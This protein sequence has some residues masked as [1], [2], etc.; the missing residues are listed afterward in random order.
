MENGSAK[1]MTKVFS[2]L[3]YAFKNI[4]KG[5]STLPSNSSELT[6]LQSETTQTNPMYFSSHKVNTEVARQS[7]SGINMPEIQQS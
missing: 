5:I 1:K 6:W 4:L 7:E 2:I 3:H